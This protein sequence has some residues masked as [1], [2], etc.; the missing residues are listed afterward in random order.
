MRPSRDHGV[1]RAHVISNMVRSPAEGYDVY[2]HLK[3]VAE[4]FLDIRVSYLGHV[5]QDE[6]L[7]RAVQRQR[8]V[9]EAFPG[10]PSSIAFRDI[11]NRVRGWT[12]PAGARGDMEFFVERLV[13]AGVVA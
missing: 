9:L 7:R 5:P 13:G 3:R 8:A 1:A 2:D 11:A 10:A 6:Y 4:R 12:P